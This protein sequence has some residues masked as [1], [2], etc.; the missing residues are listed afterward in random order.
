MSTPVESPMTDPGRMLIVYYARC[1]SVNLLIL[2][3]HGY[4]ASG[5]DN[6]KTGVSVRYEILASFKRLKW[7]SPR[8]GSLYTILQSEEEWA[9]AD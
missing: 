2:D 9:P 1:L 3:N 6:F 8:R 7:K 5:S 4:T